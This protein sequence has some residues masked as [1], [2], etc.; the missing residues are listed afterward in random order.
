MWR[1]VEAGSVTKRYFQINQY[2]FFASTWRKTIDFA[3]DSGS[4]IE[5]YP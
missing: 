5:G 3:A 1:L 2:L 4:R